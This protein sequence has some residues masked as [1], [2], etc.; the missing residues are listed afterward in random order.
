[1]YTRTATV[2]NSTGMHARPAAVF[3]A[4]AGKYK[5]MITVQGAA[6]KAVNAKSIV[7]LL[8]LG[9]SK[10]TEVKVTGQGEDEKEAVDALISLIES[11]FGEA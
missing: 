6:D 5:S 9:I 8:G 7:F 1:M 10:G 3:A 4:E 11:G 2:C